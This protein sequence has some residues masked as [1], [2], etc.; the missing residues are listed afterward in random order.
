MS[1]W[2]MPPRGMWTYSTFYHR[3]YK[4]QWLQIVI[5]SVFSWFKNFEVSSLSLFYRCF[6]FC[7]IMLLPLVCHRNLRFATFDF[8]LILFTFQLKVWVECCC[9]Q[10]TVKGNRDEKCTWQIKEPR[11]TSAHIA[12]WIFICIMCV[13]LVIY[14]MYGQVTT[15]RALQKVSSLFYLHATGLR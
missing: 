12:E 13:S 9:I 8:F 15:M 14:F 5:M 3:L 6:G 1:H 10:F 7:Y 4:L 11:D 2:Y